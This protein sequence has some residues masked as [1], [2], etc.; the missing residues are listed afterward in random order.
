MGMGQVVLVVVRLAMLV[1]FL[2]IVQYRYGAAEGGV[3]MNEA[4]CSVCHKCRSVVAHRFHEQ[5]LEK[6]M[7]S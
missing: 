5:P 7:R 1:A 2:H 3:T 4:V 6:G